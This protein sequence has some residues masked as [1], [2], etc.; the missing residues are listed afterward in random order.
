MNEQI[1]QEDTHRSGISLSLIDT[2]IRLMTNERMSNKIKRERYVQI[3]LHTVH[4]IYFRHNTSSFLND[5]LVWNGF[6]KR[7]FVVL[8]SDDVSGFGSH[9]LSLQVGHFRAVLLALASRGVVTLHAVQ[10]IL[11]TAG[12]THL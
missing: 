7:R 9:R 3:S 12:V 2:H 11:T 5:K 10:E 8:R 6:E 1:F 4:V